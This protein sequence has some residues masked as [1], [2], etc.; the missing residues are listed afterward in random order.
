MCVL[1]GLLYLESSVDVGDSPA[2]R[3]AVPS[4]DQL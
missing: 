2:G 1:G 3:A 4:L